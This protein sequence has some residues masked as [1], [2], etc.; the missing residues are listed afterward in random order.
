MKDNIFG[1]VT[2][3]DGWN[4]EESISLWGN[5]FEI[6]VTAVAYYENEPIT[7]EQQASYSDFLDEKQ[8]L[9]QTI[10]ALLLD[11]ISEAEKRLCPQYLVF[12]K[13][14]KYAL[15]FDDSADPDDGVAV[16]LSPT[17]KVMSQ[18]AYL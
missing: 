15:L 12:E 7:A 13:D 4:K 2:F 11:Y 18:D 1:I 10:E 6:L 5:D 17:R 14:G 8:V 9:L 3:D 16:Q